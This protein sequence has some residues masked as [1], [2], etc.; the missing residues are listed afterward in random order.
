MT[1]RQGYAYSREWHLVLIIVHSWPLPRFKAMQKNAARSS[2]RGRREV[3]ITRIFSVQVKSFL[4]CVQVW[5]CLIHKFVVLACYQHFDDSADN[6][7]D[8]AN[9]SL[10]E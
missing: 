2:R 3:S 4:I 9:F 8:N 10:T 6:Q 7:F 5:V 1:N